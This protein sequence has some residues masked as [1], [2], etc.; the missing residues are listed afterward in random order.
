MSSHSH[1]KELA[2]TFDDSPR[3]ANGYLDGTSRSK[4]LVEKLRQHK[5]SQVAF[6]SVSNKL[7]PEGMER[8]ARYASAGHIIANHTHS[9]ADF[10]KI[11]LAEYSRDFLTGHN[12]LKSF[13]NFRKW[14]RFPYL[15]EGDTLEK[16]DGMREL[17]RKHNYKNAYI[18]LNNYDWYIESLFQKA[19][20]E[21]IDI[22]MERMELFYIQQLLN[23]INYY[24]QMAVKHLGRSP[25]HVLLLH[26]MD[27]SALF[28]GGLI[29]ALKNQ[30]WKIISLDEAFTDDI[31]S[32]KTEHL[33]KF[34]PGRIGEIAK[35]NGQSKHLWHPS[36]DEKYLKEQF[37]KLVLKR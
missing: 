30:G 3:V 18:T 21:G 17:L 35:D 29:D 22:D 19:F 37:E 9:H 36:L 26:E 5:V 28:I 32:Y 12:N 6:F 13:R 11:T 7:D 8:L 20:A 27:I 33:F 34:N 24:D 25:K 14:F 2:I 1:T 31:A 16:R 15:R 23:S 4:I 10:N